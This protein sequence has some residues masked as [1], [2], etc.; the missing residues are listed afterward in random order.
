MKKLALLP[1][2]LLL[3]ASAL[4]SCSTNKAVLTAANDNMYFMASDM[5]KVTQHAVTN[6]QPNT[7]DGL[8]TATG[9]PQDNF[10]SKNV[11]PDY[12]ARYGQVNAQNSSDVVYFDENQDANSGT[13]P[14]IDVYNNFSVSN[15]NSGWGNTSFMPGFS[16]FGYGMMGF[17]P[18]GMGFYDPFFGPGWGW[19][20]G[21]NLGFNWGW[22]R[23][24]Y[25]PFNPYFGYNSFY[26][27]YWGGSMWGSPWGSPWGWNTPIYATGPIIIMPGNE[28]GDR[29]IVYGARPSRGSSMSSGT[30]GVAQYS[31]VPTTARAQARQN[32]ANA[33]DGVSPRRSVAN[34]SNR[35]A[36]SDFSSS[37][38]D[39]YNTGRSRVASTSSGVNSPASDRGAV[40]P[41]RSSS[42]SAR[43]SATVPS[44]SRSA[45]SSPSRNSYS[46]GTGRSYSG[47]GPS[48][49]RSSSEGSYSRS[50][51]SFGRSESSSYSSGGAPSRS[52]SNSGF[53]APSRMSTG[54]GFSAPSRSSS[55]S[56]GGSISGGSRGRGN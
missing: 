45:Y 32:V 40:V 55:G 7:F 24:Y 34:E 37:Q 54:G 48:Y 25:S 13:T 41:S 35:M 27:P 56:S 15:F 30:G 28:Y 5:K 26:S 1:A 21:L 52:S 38:N 42:T 43:P 19:R 44:S 49:N 8:A 33:S 47:E 46:T 31:G 53:S 2:S 3:G 18:W 14:N 12:L 10:S 16:P 39:Y 36:T 6:N 50:S 4:L 9:A 29:R 22:G 20:S 17:S 51:S 11:N 23:P